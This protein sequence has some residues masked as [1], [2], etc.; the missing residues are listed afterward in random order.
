[1]CF[2]AFTSLT[3][4]DLFMAER[5]TVAAEVSSGIYKDWVYCSCK[6]LADGLLLRAV[7]AVLYAIPYVARS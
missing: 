4:V 6:L 5:D 1:M 7:P 2:L 3:S